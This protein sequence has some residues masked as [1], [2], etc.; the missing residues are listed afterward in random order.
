MLI[1]ILYLAL[2]RGFNG[3]PEVM[4]GES[5]AMFL[6]Q[7]LTSN[8]PAAL[9][10]DGVLNVAVW[11]IY[12]QKRSSWQPQLKQI[13]DKSE[14]VLLQEAKLDQSLS[15]Y[16]KQRRRHM[17]MGK[18]FKLLNTPMGV[19]NIASAS[20]L[21]ACAY[22]TVEPWIRFA[23]STLISSYA[24]SSGQTLLVINLHG[25]NFDWKLDRFNAQWQQIVH[26]IALHHGPT[27]VAGDFNTWRPA[28]IEL[29]N[30]LTARL[31]LKEVKYHRDQRQRVF[32][33]PLD[34][35]YYRGLHLVEAEAFETRASDHNPITARF[36]LM[37]V[38]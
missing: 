18:G 27:I 2:V 34:H 33:Y 26:K 6:G 28:R 23:K 10:T 9:D 15:D 38:N 19:M 11:N 3:Q 30:E 24:L 12:K 20:V 37:P 4:M 35:L 16:L 14:L 5:K 1:C 31:K 8:K 32:G 25:I 17:V 36:T 21:D 13:L 7:C 29:V 22:Q